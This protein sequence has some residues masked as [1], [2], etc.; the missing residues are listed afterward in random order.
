MKNLTSDSPRRLLRAAPWDGVTDDGDISTALLP[1]RL[2]VSDRWEGFH[3][4]NGIQLVNC[5]PQGS[6]FGE[7]TSNSSTVKGLNGGPD[8]DPTWY[9]RGALDDSFYETNDGQHT[10]ISRSRETSHDYNQAEKFC[11]HN[12]GIRACCVIKKENQRTLALS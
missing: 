2:S 12:T 4:K 8:S 1:S 9:Y 3:L 7:L 6:S 5:V 10:L 11:Q